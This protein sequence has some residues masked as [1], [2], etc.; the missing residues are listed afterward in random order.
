MLGS[1][2]AAQLLQRAD[3]CIG[4]LGDLGVA[5]RPVIRLESRSKQERIVARRDESRR[6]TSED[7]NWSK[8]P[9]CRK[10]KI[11]NSRLDLL[12][13]HRIRKNKRKITLDCG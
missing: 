3:D 10:R 1:L 4:P 13:G 7:F 12:E 9:K 2:L 6:P 8:T 11:V 5:Q